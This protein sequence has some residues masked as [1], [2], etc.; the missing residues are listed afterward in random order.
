MILRDSKGQVVEIKITGYQF[1]QEN[2]A[3]E[4]DS[5]WLDINITVKT[6][7]LTWSKTDPSLLTWE[8]QSLIDWIN[9]ISSDKI[10]VQ[11]EIDFIEPNLSFK[12]LI[13]KPQAKLLRVIFK[14]ESSPDF[15][16]EYPVDLDMT[17]SQ[18]KQ[19]SVE[20]SN[21]LC[22]YPQR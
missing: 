12:L 13:N 10:E 5:N 16:N 11:D 15:D 9:N 6:F 7:D 8:V 20:L 22:N 17:G 19:A 3:S 18:L 4:Y 21:E 14:Y 1:S 2:S